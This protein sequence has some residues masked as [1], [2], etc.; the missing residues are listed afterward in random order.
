MLPISDKKIYRM[1]ILRTLN[2]LRFEN[3]F[4]L[5]NISTC[6][7]DKSLILSIAPLTNCIKTASSGS[8]YE[9]TDHA[10][11]ANLKS[12]TYFDLFAIGQIG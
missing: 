4:T 6:F 9:F 2:L 7:Y 10:L 5:K 11:C 8:K 3:I 1:F 12:S